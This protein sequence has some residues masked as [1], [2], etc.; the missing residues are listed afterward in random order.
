MKKLL[1]LLAVVLFVMTFSVLAMARPSTLLGMPATTAIS[2]QVGSDLAVPSGTLVPATMAIDEIIVLTDTAMVA[3]HR[4]LLVEIQVQVALD[5]NYNYHGRHICLLGALA[6]ENP[7]PT[8]TDGSRIQA[9]S[10]G[11]H[12]APAAYC[13][14]EEYSFGQRQQQRAAMHYDMNT[15]IVTAIRMEDAFNTGEIGTILRL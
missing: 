14:A 7:A 5:A 11:I 4:T 13:K 12:F 15:C 8:L 9:I 6:H 10:I 3:N 1:V 2:D